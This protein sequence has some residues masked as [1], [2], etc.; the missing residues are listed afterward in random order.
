MQRLA[1]E[2]HER[3]LALAAE[4]RRL[5]G[6]RTVIVSLSTGKDSV[7]LDLWLTE[8]GIEHE[9]IFLD[10]R[11]DHPAVREHLEYLRGKLGPIT[12]L[13]GPLGMV[14]LIRK[15]GMFPSRA[16]RFCTEELKTFP[17][18]DYLNARINAGDDV[19]NAVGI[20]RDESEA[21]SNMSE[22]E[23]M[24]GFDCEVWRPLIM[25]S[26]EDVVAIH[27]HHDVRPNGLYLLG[28]DRVGCWPCI[29]SNKGELRRLAELD[30]AR[31]DELR[32]LEAEIAVT[33]RARYD[34]R[35][36]KYQDGGTKALTARERGLLL[37]EQG[38]VKPFHPPHFFQ[39]PLKEEGG[40][41]WPIDR[42]VA[43]S[44]TR[45]GGRIEDKQADLL[46]FGGINDG[47]MRWGLCET[48]PSR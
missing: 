34:K 14:E 44:R 2:P 17:A 37:D 22:W 48:S 35:L 10:T 40:K 30:P 11:W 1:G 5:I 24:D 36:A 18:R 13:S 41:T 7:A 45:R 29:N 9:R 46:S 21:R 28:M 43:W 38:D 31:I 4:Y 16:R 47:C 33:A 15:K 23:W 27:K 6:D 3:R 8:L 39:S 12:E 32:Q 25:W 26:L 20:R 19:I 42:V